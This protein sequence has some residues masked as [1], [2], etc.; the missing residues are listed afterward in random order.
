M[1][2]AA[3]DNMVVSIHYTLKDEEGTVIDS[4]QGS[5]PLTYLHGAGNIIPGLENAIAGKAPG[6]SL[7]VVV[8]PGQGYG[9]Y[10][11]ELLQVVPKQAFEGVETVEPGMAFMAQAADGSQRRIV[12]RDVE[13][14]EVTVDANHELAG[15]DLHFSVDVM[16]VREATAE[17]KDHGH[18]H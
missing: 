2:L 18:A 15:V 5:E 12:V 7:Q 16:D 1:S 17:E 6:D 13:G 4:S 14:D 3:G 11:A 10:Q 9:E 8:E